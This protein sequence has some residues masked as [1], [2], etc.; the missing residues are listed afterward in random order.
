MTQRSAIAVEML[1]LL[2]EEAKSGQLSGLVNQA[3]PSSTP[4]GVDERYGANAAVAKAGYGS[5]VF[6]DR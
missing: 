6:T 2:R 1:P 3:H 4:I 5:P